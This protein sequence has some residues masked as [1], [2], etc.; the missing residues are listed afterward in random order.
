M[1]VLT[2]DR[3]ASSRLLALGRMD[4]CMIGHAHHGLIRA[5]ASL[6]LAGAF[7]NTVVA[8]YKYAVPKPK[9]QC[10]KVGIAPYT[11]AFFYLALHFFN[12]KIESGFQ[13]RYIKR[14]L[15]AHHLCNPSSQIEQLG[16]SF[17]AGYI[18]GVFCAAVSHPAD[19][20]VSKLNSK[21]GATVGDIIKDMGWYNLC[22]RGLG[23]RILM[24][25]EC[26]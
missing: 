14:T 11:M 10:S 12:F 22:T 4:G 6:L 15:P 25:G 20:L 5:V 21:K 8:L 17:A 26:A 9:D 16:V 13:N 24:V 23:L 3:P 1:L 19:N 18:A 7:E 2:S